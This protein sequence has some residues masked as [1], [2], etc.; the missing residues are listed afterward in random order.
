MLAYRAGLEAPSPGMS[1]AGESETHRKGL[2]VSVKPRTKDRRSSRHRSL[3]S[4]SGSVACYATSATSA[5]KASMAK[6]GGVRKGG[7]YVGPPRSVRVLFVGAGAVGFATGSVRTATLK[8]APE[9]S[10][11]ATAT[12]YWNPVYQPLNEARENITYGFRPRGHHTSTIS[13]K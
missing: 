9:P 1:V 12:Q 11:A 8:S 13:G 5:G 7:S 6:A 4:H 3:Y 2:H 10:L